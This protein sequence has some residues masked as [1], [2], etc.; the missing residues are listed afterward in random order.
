[1]KRILWLMLLAAA[2][3]GLPRLSHPATDIG[4]LQPVEAV[5]LTLDDAGIRIETD[6]GYRGV[7]AT[8]EEAV[9][10]LYDAAPAAI[11][12]DTANKLLISG[13][14]EPD[15]TEIL[16]VFRPS[17]R[18]CIVNGDVNLKEAADYLAVH[19]PEITLN[20]LRAGEKE[21]QILTIR[22]GRGSLEAE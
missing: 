2:V 18:V 4:R 20:R 14:E 12:L 7:G 5:L 21:R 16:S 8:L 3:W 22:E 1:M 9:K 13:E 17:C 10:D 11:Y 19:E 6:G 15:W